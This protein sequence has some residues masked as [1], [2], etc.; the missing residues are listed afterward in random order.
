M[1]NIIGAAEDSYLV[2]ADWKSQEIVIQAYLSQDQEL[3]NAVNSGDPYLY[4]AKAVGAIPKDAVRK[5]YEHE[6]E[7]Y[8]QS[9]LAIGYGQTPFGLKNKLGISLPNATYI[10]SKICGYYKVFAAWSKSI[11]AKAMQR[12]YFTTC[13]GWKYWITDKEIVNP[14]RLTNW[15]IQS[16]GSE[17]LRRAMI[18]LDEAGFE[19]SMII[20]DA[21]LL[22]CKRK[23]LRAMIDD[24][25]AIMEIMSRAAEKVIGAPI[26]V[27]RKIIRKQF[28][29]DKENQKRWN[30][31]YEKLINAKQTCKENG[32]VIYS[33]TL[34]AK[35]TPVISSK[36]V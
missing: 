17:I 9:L 19:I 12:G 2:Y 29:Q 23:N 14:R 34:T 36:Y 28:Y 11:T 5:D 22:H 20:H 15:P 8:K 4:T 26:L 1:R 21:V 13:Y 10:H 31:L 3:I 24:N 33:D 6:R 30:K 16:H 25:K 32:Q 18:D 35:S 7:L 27:D